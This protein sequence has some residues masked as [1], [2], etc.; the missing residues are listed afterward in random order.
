MLIAGTRHDCETHVFVV[1]AIV[2]VGIGI[3]IGIEV[4]HESCFKKQYTHSECPYRYAVD[5]DSGLV[6]LDL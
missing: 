2:V 1:V 4:V 3:G 5:R 6:V